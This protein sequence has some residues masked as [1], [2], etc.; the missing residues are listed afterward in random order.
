MAQITYANKTFV[1]Q[2]ANVP[3]INKVQDSDMNE[4]KS[5]VNSNDTQTTTN[6]AN[7]T[8]IVLWSNNSPG[9][10]MSGGTSINLSSSD[11]DI[12]EV[13][14]IYSTSNQTIANSFR[15]PKGKGGMLMAYT[16]EG[17][18]TIILRNLKYVSDT[19]F[20][21]TVGKLNQLTNNN[22]TDNTTGCIPIY[23]VGY[24]TGLF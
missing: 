14:V 24:K 23:I 12:L 21:L 5:V 9:T 19:S 7:I 6:I 18:P 11:Y 20:T 8:G 15:F 2:N 16:P 13:F 17:T 3:A 22:I 4:I 1:N 10:S